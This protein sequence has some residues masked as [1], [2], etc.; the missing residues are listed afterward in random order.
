M[1]TQAQFEWTVTIM[2]GR[3]CVFEN[4]VIV[5]VSVSGEDAEVMIDNIEMFGTVPRVRSMGSF[6]LDR[7][8]EQM[9]DSSNPHMVRLGNWAMETL[10]ADDDFIQK[11]RDEAGLVYVG[12][13]GNDPDGHFRRVA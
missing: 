6:A 4:D 5:T 10:L 7:V 3:L 2:Q 12:L 1:A 8:V 11:A 13:G 9:T